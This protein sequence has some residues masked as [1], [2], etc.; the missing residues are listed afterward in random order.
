VVRKILQNIILINYMAVERW[1]MQVVT[2]IGGN[3]RIIRRKDMEHMS[4]L[5]DTDIS[6]SG[7]RITCTGME[8]TDGQMEEYAMDS[9]KSIR[10][11]VTDI[12]GMMMAQNILDSTRMMYEMETQF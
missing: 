2:G 3:S 8:Y 5:V 7:C 10:R 1:N 4:G 9:G 12:R 6:G 11:M